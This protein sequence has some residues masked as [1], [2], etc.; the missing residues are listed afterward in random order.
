MDRIAIAK[1]FGADHEESRAVFHLQAADG[2][3][4]F[5]M[6][7]IGQAQNGRQSDKRLAHGQLVNSQLGM[8]GVRQCAAMESRDERGELEVPLRPARWRRNF[9]NHPVGLFVV[10]LSFLETPGFLKQRRRVQYEPF[11]DRGF[12]PD[13]TAI[14]PG[15]R[16]TAAI[17][18]P[19]AGPG[20]NRASRKRP[21]L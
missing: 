8:I 16:I 1:P 5:G 6:K 7:R 20:E 3:V 9:A 18:A 17:T 10:G 21:T 15:H 4:R 11:L 14:L 19:S 2:P 13:Q 12:L